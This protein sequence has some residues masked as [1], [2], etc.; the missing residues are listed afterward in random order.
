LFDE[1]HRAT[2]FDAGDSIGEASADGAQPFHGDEQRRARLECNLDPATDLLLAG[3]EAVLRELRP[4]QLDQDGNI[5]ALRLS[6]LCH[7]IHS[8]PCDLR[9]KGRPVTRRA[10]GTASR[11]GDLAGL[12]NVE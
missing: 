7:W 11:F 9:R 8:L 1:Q 12:E 4:E 3:G 2:M 5:P 10:N 6:D